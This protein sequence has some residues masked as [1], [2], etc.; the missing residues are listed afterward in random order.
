MKNIMLITIDCLRKD[1]IAPEIMPAMHRLKERGLSFEDVITHSSH[2]SIA[3]LSMFASVGFSQQPKRTLPGVLNEHGYTTAGI[4]SQ[5]Q[6]Y[7]IGVSKVAED[8]QYMNSLNPRALN[9]IRKTRT[10]GI[11][12][13]LRSRHYKFYKVGQKLYK[14]AHKTAKK[15]YKRKHNRKPTWADGKV[16]NTCV[17][18][19]ADTGKLKQPFFL[20]IHYLDPHWKYDPPKE[21][22]NMNISDEE[23][24]RL[25]KLYKETP[26]KVGRGNFRK[27]EELYRGEVRYVDAKI[28][29]LLSFLEEKGLMDNTI[30]VVSAD[31]GEEF[32]EH[33][34]TQHSVQLYD[35]VVNVPFIVHGIGKKGKVEGQ[36]GHINL[37]PTIL[38]LLGLPEEEGF[39]GK[40]MFEGS[41]KEIL[42]KT[43]RRKLGIRTEQ[44]KYISPGEL[45]NLKEDPGEK[46]NVAEE[47]PELVRKFEKKLEP[48][49]K[50]EYKEK[51]IEDEEVKSRLKAL[52]YMD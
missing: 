21:Y 36:R 6:M 14:M 9:L 8:F 40:S 2:T 51:E 37:A 23:V 11:A 29:E 33:G 34:G 12:Y 7:Q 10:T 20:W 15:F 25:N 43:V 32:F 39:Q 13:K 27:I 46:I 17:H 49:K 28:S 35:E 18:D 22:L 45:Y 16:L 31:H 44:W 1:H 30:T 42:M 47:N 19:L 24:Y 5:P 52:G 48:Y 26:E 41:D 4:T 38:D 50:E 3:F